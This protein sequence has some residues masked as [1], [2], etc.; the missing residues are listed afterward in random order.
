MKWLAN[1]AIIPVKT[2]VLSAAIAARGATNDSIY[3]VLQ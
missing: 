2:K 1:V 3:G